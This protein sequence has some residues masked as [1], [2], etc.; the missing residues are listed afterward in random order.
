VKEE[1]SPRSAQGVNLAACAVAHWAFA[2]P[3]ALALTMID[4]F[5]SDP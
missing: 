3:R 5:L 1:R 4:G 2:R